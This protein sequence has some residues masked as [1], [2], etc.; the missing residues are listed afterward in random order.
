MLLKLI[1]FHVLFNIWMNIWNTVF[2]F[3]YDVCMNIC[4]VTSC[5]DKIIKPHHDS[6]FLISRVSDAGINRIYL[7]SAGMK[8]TSHS[9]HTNIFL[10]CVTRDFSLT[11]TRLWWPTWVSFDS[12]WEALPRSRQA[13]VSATHLDTTSC[14]SISTQAIRRKVTKTS[15]N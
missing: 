15:C 3:F 2:R 1:L 9:A 12:S 13:A 11:T 7:I 10:T 14:L 6:G 5:E 8:N 4:S